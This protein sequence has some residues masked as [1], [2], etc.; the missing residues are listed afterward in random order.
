MNEVYLLLGS[1][2]D[3]EKNIL[4]ALK[5]LNQTFKII[6][7][8]NTWQTK[9]V[10][11]SA[12]DFLNT[13]VK[14]ETILDVDILKEKC[15]CHIEEMLGRVRQP[16]KNAPRTIDLDIIIFNGDIIDDSLFRFAHLIIPF[17][18]LL[19]DLVDP[20]T[21]KTLAVLATEQT[22][23]TLAKKFKC[24]IPSFQK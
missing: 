12:N 24:L 10:G 8:S 3:P 7:V 9:P 13:A 20:Q 16:D 19:P 5:Y 17:S 4:L 14:L 1:N 18:E 2:I 21:Q 6:E 11:S 22:K 15:L 23:K